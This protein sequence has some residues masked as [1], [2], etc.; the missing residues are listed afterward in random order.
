MSNKVYTYNKITEL[1]KA[2]YFTE[3]API[4]Q[5]TMSRELAAS[6]AFD[7]KI[8]RGN[9]LG[10][11]S[12]QQRLFPGW[13]T[14]GQK[15]AFIT[16]LNQ[17]MREKIGAEKDKAERDWLYGCK[18]NLYAAISNMIR[19]EEAKVCPEDLADTDRDLQ[20]FVQMW[21]L[22]EKKNDSIKE[23]RIQRERLKEEKYFDE[24]V[25]KIFKFHGRK[26]IVWNGFQF[27]TPMQRF[28]FEC[29]RNAGYETDAL[30][31][32]EERYPYA[33]EIWNHLYDGKNGFPE[34]SR[35]IRQTQTLPENPL[36]EIFETGGRSQA[37]NI[38]MIRYN[39]TMEFIE[40][41]PRIKNAGYYLYCPDDHS[42]NSM[43]KD[44]FPERYEDRN[45]LSYPIGQFVYALHQMWD[46]KLQCIVLDQNG[47][48]K[49]FASGWLSVH[50]KSSSRYTEEL[51]RL[52]PYFD[53]CYTIK[54]WSDRLKNLIDSCENAVNVFAVDQ[55]SDLREKRRSERFGNPLK[56]FGAYS[57][58]EDR[59]NEVTAIIKQLLEMAKKLFGANEPL[60]IQEHMSKLDALLC[61][62]DGMPKE[63]NQEERSKVKKIFET[64]ENEKIRDFLC[65]PG[66]LAPALLSFMRDKMEADDQNNRGLKTL[67]FNIFQIEAAPLA[68]KGKVHLCLAD[69]SRLPG[70]PA[71]YSWPLDEETLRYVIGKKQNTYLPNWIENNELTALSNRYYVYTALKNENV[72]I[73]WIQKQGEKLYSPSPYITL[74]ARLTGSRICS[75][76]VRTLDMQH[77]SEVMPRRIMEKDY[78]IREQSAIHSYEMELEYSFCPMRFVYSYVLGDTAA[79]RNEF[80]QNRA[81][82]RFIQS[83]KAL[84]GEEY[85]LEQI[86][87]RVF[88][89]FPGIR[90]AEKRQMIDD[91]SRW[92]LPDHDQPYTTYGEFSY[93]NHRRDLMFLDTRCYESAKR[94]AAML[95]SPKGRRGI[96]H[97]R[98]GME[99][100][101]NCQFC[102]HSGYC[103][104]SLFGVD[105]KGDQE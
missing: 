10:F 21:K 20:L 92:S 12:F 96:F 57:I 95:G 23:F 55:V 70:T 15:F 66:D 46:E 38:R 71:A 37:A 47:L 48:R 7:M 32:D 74:L 72:E 82:V 33:N 31:Q 93:T 51:E 75:S 49:C 88:E 79:Y 1:K 30:I 90:K 19:L 83:L 9:I 56:F 59:L 3:I 64:L 11:S 80:Q 81:I 97:D 50:G 40:D 53:G 34:R 52:L 99:G 85:T 76:E 24:E 42:A 29:F 35:W 101:R 73:S 89:L 28:L 44:Y 8:F 2:A 4:P 36:G 77:V 27:L 17:F 105:Y 16:I 102:P 54:E 65:Y 5:L 91:A 69:I 25:N 86:A 41:I 45:L 62:N 6:M 13:N 87:E 61:M 63:L 22:L 94:Q 43:L 18:K 14:S 98:N 100:A 26:K 67:V 104:K 58:R 68:A 39:N 78:D 84:L 60:S 103:M